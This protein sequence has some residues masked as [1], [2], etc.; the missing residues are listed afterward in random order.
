MDKGRFSLLIPDDKEFICNKSISDR[1]YAWILINGRKENGDIYIEKTPVGAYKQIGINY[2]TFYNRIWNLVDAGYLEEGECEYKVV[3]DI[4]KYKRF[5]YKDIVQTLLDTK[6]DNIIKV[7]IELATL[8]DTAIKKKQQPFFRY[9]NL[10]ER[11]GYYNKGRSSFNENKM[12]SIVFKL[13]EL[14][15]IE[16][17]QKYIKV[18]DNYQI[19]NILL[20]V[21]TK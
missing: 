15:L 2:R 13:K 5:V 14:K 20:N 10:C 21:R 3:K 8:Y 18:G 7:Y 11:L 1:V 4:S 9:N 12:K 16:Y 19:N 6:I 17:E